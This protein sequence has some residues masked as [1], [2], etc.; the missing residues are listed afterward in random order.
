MQYIQFATTI[1]EF[2]FIVG[3]YVL[4]SRDNTSVRSA[5][6]RVWF[7]GHFSG[8]WLRLSYRTP[9]M[10]PK[11]QTAC[12]NYNAL[13][14]HSLLQPYSAEPTLLAYQYRGPRIKS[15]MYSGERGI[16]PRT[17]RSNSRV[18][19]HYTTQPSLCIRAYKIDKFN[20]FLNHFNEVERY[21]AYAR[22]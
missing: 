18:C 11:Y 13:Y 5:G 16:E 15:Q 8:F 22:T 1:C 20:I 2:L 21:Y 12:V 19:N 10:Q 7:L 17:L 14:D 9:R 3:C 4:P 6:S